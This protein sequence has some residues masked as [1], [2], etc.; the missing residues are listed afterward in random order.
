MKFKRNRLLRR[1]AYIRDL[2]QETT[3]QPSDF[4]LPFFITSGNNIKKESQN[5]PG[6]YKMSLDI[7][8]QEALEVKE[9]GIRGILLFVEVEKNKKD[10]TGKEALNENGLMQKSIRAIKKTV[11]ELVI[12]TDIALD[13]YSIYGHDGIVKDGQIVN[14][15]TIEILAQIAVTHAKAGADF[16]APSDMMDGRILAIRE[17]LDAYK[18]HQTGILSY[19]A[20]YASCFYGPFRDMLNST[21]GFGDKK[22]YQMNIANQKEALREAHCD[23]DEGAD[24][25]MVKPALN[26][27]DII[28]LLKKEIR[29]TPIAAYQVSGEYAMIKA[30]AAK[31][32]VDEKEAMLETITSIKRAGADIIV[33]YFAK[34][35]IRSI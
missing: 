8:T 1:T 17:R 27:L 30:A 24:I 31:G 11:P 28:H 4:I 19:S 29:T 25:I 26:F 35:F 23:I 7:A 2:V 34:D 14:D 16:V 12:L 5:L 13:P 22:S 21:P 15:P 33:S 20:K 6:Y 3:L 18:Y 10:N 9:M 32:W